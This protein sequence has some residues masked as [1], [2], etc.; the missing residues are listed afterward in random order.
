[1]A[2]EPGRRESRYAH[3][4]GGEIAHRDTNPDLEQSAA[5][6]GVSAPEMSD[7]A[8]GQEQ[9]LTRLEREVQALHAELSELKRRL[10]G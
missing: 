6:S 8:S 5:S 1:L 9:R 4:F 3:R 7:L 10:G 2:R